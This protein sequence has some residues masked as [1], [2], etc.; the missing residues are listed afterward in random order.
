MAAQEE[1]RTKIIIDGSAAADGNTQV[2][3]SLSN[4]ANALDRALGKINP[5]VAVAKQLGREQQELAKYVKGVETAYTELQGKSAVLDIFK[6]RQEVLLEVQKR[7]ETGTITL[8][9]AQAALAG[10]IKTTTDLVGSGSRAYLEFMANIDK[11]AAAELAHIQAQELHKAKLAELQ[12]IIKQTTLSQIEQ[13]EALAKLET[14][15][16][17][18]LL[19]QKATAE[20]M[21][22]I[23]IAIR[24]YREELGLEDSEVRKFNEGQAELISLLTKDGTSFKEATAILAAYSAQKDP[25][26]K[27]EKEEAQAISD[28]TD[29][30]N[31]YKT[32]LGLVDAAELKFISG[33]DELIK[34]IKDG[35][36]SFSEG[37]ALLSAYNLT[38][39]PAIKKEKELADAAVK[40]AADRA[41]V[42]KGL[43]D[44]IA[45][46]TKG[47]QAK[48]DAYR[49]SLIAADPLYAVEQQRAK[50]LK[51]LAEGQKAAKQSDE[52]YASA[53][54]KVNVAMDRHKQVAIE[55]EKSYQQLAAAGGLSR[56]SMLMLNASVI[57]T[58]QSLSAGLP[59]TMVLSQQIPQVAGAFLQESSA[60]S[61]VTSSAVGFIS[62][63]VGLVAGLGAGTAVLAAGTV[64]ALMYSSSLT[65]VTTAAKLA[66]SGI[67]V[68]TGEFSSF[69]SRTSSAGNVSR[70]FTR[71]MVAQFT[72]MGK[73]APETMGRIIELTRDYAAVTGLDAADAAKKLG[74]QMQSP[75]E[76][77]KKLAVEIGLLTQVQVRQ[78]EALETAGNRQAAAGVI[79][80]AYVARIKTAR[81][82]L[83]GVVRGWQDIGTAV[84]NVWDWVGEGIA[85]AVFDTQ[86]LVEK[87]DQTQAELDKLSGGI[88]WKNWVPGLS[89]T[90]EYTRLEAALAKLVLRKKAL[91]DQ[92]EKSELNREAA[93]IE[94]L[95]TQYAAAPGVFEKTEAAIERMAKA[96]ANASS[97]AEKNRLILGITVGTKQNTERSNAGFGPGSALNKAGYTEEEVRK[98]NL[99]EIEKKYAGQLSATAQVQKKIEIDAEN[100][101]FTARSSAA[102][103]IAQ[104]EGAVALAEA[105]RATAAE[106]SPLVEVI[107]K[108]E[109]QIQEMAGAWV[110]A[111]NAA[112]SRLESA[113]AAKTKALQELS[114]GGFDPQTGVNADGL[115]VE[116]QRKKELIEIDKK[117]AGQL[118]QS[119]RERKAQ[120]VAA[121]NSRY[122]E[123]TDGEDQLTQQEAL[124]SV[125][126]QATQSIAQQ[127]ATLTE[128]A[129]LAVAQAAAW[130]GM[131]SSAQTYEGKLADIIVSEAE[132][133]ARNDAL[134][135]SINV[136]ARTRQYVTEAVLKQAAASSQ[137]TAVL[138]NE[139][140]EQKKVTE[141]TLLGV[142]ARREALLQVEIDKANAPTLAAA[143]AAERQGNLDAADALRLKADEYARVAK[144]KKASEFSDFLTQQLKQ[145]EHQN[146]LLKEQQ[147][148][149]GASDATKAAVKA[150]RE[151]TEAVYGQ[152]H[153]YDQLQGKEKEFVDNLI[154][155]KQV[156]AELELSIARQE[157]AWGTLTSSLENAFGKVGDAITEAFAKGEIKS[158]NW[159]NVTKAV[160]SSVVSDLLKM[161]LINPLS[162]A[163]FG[164]NKGTIFDLFSGGTG[165]SPLTGQAANNN[166][167]FGGL[168][169]LSLGGLVSKASGGW[170]DRQLG[171]GISD[172]SGWLR[173]PVAGFQDL[174][175]GMYGPAAPNSSILGNTS[176]GDAL[177]GG[178]YGVGALANFAN[179]NIGGGI[180]NSAAAIMSFIPGLQ[181]FAPLAA[182]AGQLLGGLFGKDRG[183]PAAAARVEYTGSKLTGGDQ[184][185]DN[186]GDAA[187]AKQLY[188]SIN[189]ATAKFML[190]SGA[191]TPNGAFGIGVEAKDGK[192]RA[193]TGAGEVGSFGTLDEAV[194]AQFRKN[195]SD[196]LISASDDVLKAVANST[197]TDINDFMSDVSFAKDFR[198]QFDAMNAALDPTNNQIKTYTENAKALGEQ[199]KT[200]ILDWK[201]SAQ[202]LGLATDEQLVTAAKRGVTAMMGLGPAVEP[203]RGVAAVTKQA[204]IQFEAFKPALS[205]L[206]YTA[207]EV[208]DLASQYVAK[209]VKARDDALTLTKNQGAAAI[210]GLTDPLAKT[211]VSDRFTGLGLDPSNSV[212]AG[213]AAVI[214]G[215]EAAARAGTLSIKS[216][217]A[218]LTA[219]NDQL[220]SGYLTA[221]QYASV[222]GLLTQAWQ[223]SA[224]AAAAA[225]AKVQSSEDLTVR[226]LRAQGLT[227]Q[228]DD[229]ARRL[230]AQRAYQEAEKEG[231]DASYLA[232]LRY[233]QTVEDI[234][235]VTART[236][237]AAKAASE[238]QQAAAKATLEAQRNSENLTVRSLRAQGMEAQADDY[239]LGLKQL[240]E[241]Q[242]AI[243]AGWSKGDLAGL[244]YV[245]A[246][247]KAAK[248][249]TLA[250]EAAQKKAAIDEANSD[251]FQRAITASGNS[252]WA[253]SR[254]A[255]IE[256][257]KQRAS[258]VATGVTG[259]DLANLDTVLAYDK[260]QS[261]FQAAQ[262]AYQSEVD[263]QIQAINDNTQSAR[264]LVTANIQFAQ[265]VRQAA[266]DR[267][268][269]TAISPLGP[270]AQLEEARKQVEDTY[271]KA[272]SGDEDARSR[273]VALMNTLDQISKGYYASSD[274]TDFNNNQARLESLGLAAS[275]QLDS[276]QQLV[277]LADQEL[278]VLQQA[279]TDAN[280]LGQ[281]SLFSLDSLHE[282][283]LSANDSLQAVIP[284]VLALTGQ[285][286]LGGTAGVVAP[287]KGGTT[288]TRSAGNFVTEWFSRYNALIGGMNSGSIGSADAQTQGISLYNEKLSFAGG[289]SGDPAVWN[290]VIVAAQNSQNGAD[291]ANWFKGLAH[292][293]GVPGYV[294]GGL[295]T[296]GVYN[297]D[298]VFAHLAGKEYVTKATSV[299]AETFPVLASINATAKVPN[300]PSW[301]SVSP[302]RFSSNENNKIEAQLAQANQQIAM[303]T[304]VIDF[305]GR[306]NVK[307]HQDNVA[308]AEI[309]NAKLSSVA[310]ATARQAVRN[311]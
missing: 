244:E 303:L 119:S 219:L 15:Y 60:L 309:G 256:A 133:K 221:D 190:A 89:I 261:V 116:L 191:K 184:A 146:V 106:Y 115:T 167:G 98:L 204:E 257:V 271:A 251:I 9:Q 288:A 243:T 161:A 220:D 237:E 145:I 185:T 117:Y 90:A 294:S 29:K 71:D 193:Y 248:A 307:G 72:S 138:Q 230:A 46:V 297:Q 159:G 36:V 231:Y 298:S 173:S 120:D 18:L 174:P 194:I 209:L 58:V 10:K 77:A 23:R 299:N 55:S 284:G 239:E 301:T 286:G 215:V 155:Q 282:V 195:V 287:D 39:D 267:L 40:S 205:A 157:D 202:K 37:A 258:A 150:Q 200:S 198:S 13:A 277:K 6:Q 63:N 102:D 268:L 148:L 162:N 290:A 59:V 113:I 114:A 246:M 149:V 79:L 103:L 154:K 266:K 62:A 91:D 16:N 38:H 305:Y 192:Y 86:G 30:I 188:D 166:G 137:A 78:I 141:A 240:R 213:L 253:A 134:T 17:P 186:E 164:T 52:E 35:N 47:E 132:S 76:S 241:M 182:I 272:I 203:L 57:N 143:L 196:G 181:E 4:M 101:R 210:A 158:I 226:S 104:K 75:S 280:A 127:N 295:V 24:G 110:E 64:A 276:S 70:G 275:D 147:K 135:L 100:R 69:V 122:K 225:A 214:G 247:E 236:A 201:D 283:L 250:A 22:E 278:K 285:L 44:D 233:V 274:A 289:L 105:I 156:N 171:G 249:T 93:E 168:S 264:A 252:V 19:K 172:V 238:A 245:H 293:K 254:A 144:E 43:L 68:S 206:G 74:E 32:D 108:L 12:T 124:N 96:W 45:S 296:N 242:D 131:F 270:K 183:K 97:E 228:A 212:I 81:D 151:I 25:T 218:A 217:Q 94:N 255:D 34:T 129:R 111:D 84:K 178:L 208:A 265:T 170:L 199:V 177:G 227:E 92:I 235:S 263:R 28:L 8:G 128:S 281:K 160:I 112:K 126:N 216:E 21:Q 180:G 56:N 20:S 229:Y 11:T 125:R 136:E 87:I 304:K 259:K 222:V 27:K 53:I 49:Q 169:Q 223:D 273:I 118:G 142:D 187:Q 189:A 121:A 51:Q 5:M 82:E 14:A 269:D 311:R 66:G 26:I 73:I 153:A 1:I 211:S 7:L 123:R 85:G 65:S 139:V 234:A 163:A 140:D 80:D 54:N 99:I 292:D 130:S 260:A 207:A 310:L 67:A 308:V 232:G 176:W 291:T 197:K 224:T 42:Q 107:K 109:D 61:K 306:Q 33:R 279:K 48:A 83:N 31:K 302:R 262:T 300:I 152:G 175:A 50:L 3:L 95:L 2:S 179:G 41:K 88:S 165:Q